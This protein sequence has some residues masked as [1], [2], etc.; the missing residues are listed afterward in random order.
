[1]SKRRKRKRV[2]IR[3]L[4]VS[5][6][7]LMLVLTFFILKYISELPDVN[8][9]ANSGKVDDIAAAWKEQE[10]EEIKKPDDVLGSPS[11]TLMATPSLTLT[12][13]PHPTPTDTPIPEVNFSEQYAHLGD[14]KEVY[15][16]GSGVAYGL[17]YPLYEDE[18]CSDAVRKAAEA[19]LTEQLDKFRR[20]IDKDCKLVIDYEDG[21]FG[22]LLSV[23]FRVEREI[24][25]VKE[26]EVKPWVY[27]KKNG[28]AVEAETLFADPAYTYIADRI[29]EASAK[30]DAS[31][32]RRIAGNR[33]TFSA[34]LLTA[35]GA[36]FFYEKDGEESSV[37][38]PYPELHTYM[39]VTVGGTVV[40]ET[41]RQLDP[42]KPMIALTF[43]DG[44]H[45]KNTPWLLD[46]LEEN[47]AR[48]TFF[49]LGSRTAWNGSPEA[50][51]K[52]VASGNEIASHTQN[53]KDL[54]TLSIEA[55]NAEITDAREAIYALTG[56]YPTF[57]RAPYGSYNDTVKK[58]VNAPL[59][60][61]NLDSEDWKSGDR[62]TIISHVLEEAGDGKIVLMHDIHTC[63]VE[64]V[65][66]LIPKLQEKGYQIVTVRE[67]FYYKGV[68]PVNGVVY[69]SSYN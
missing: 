49:L 51:E 68:E 34:Y 2:L 20:S 55:L 6:C 13:T 66:V 27:N 12:A 56:D 19:L 32:N 4:L 44:P 22:E 42:E 8:A 10:D 62:D 33:E 3:V 41:I 67:L 53:H 14:F 9:Y 60:L 21:T 43:D 17:R 28:E 69:H 30:D 59:V 37:T 1:M 50:V 5:C 58:H 35:D 40:A 31:E 7:A 39:S 48:S 65:E 16:Y 24:D 11:P 47:N 61:W 57:V 63:T 54:A 29:N 38:I 25:G 23:L 36:K 18:N 46:V 15:A 26:F 52:L 45:Y 64:A